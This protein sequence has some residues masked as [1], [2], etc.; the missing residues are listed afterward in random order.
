MGFLRTWNTSAKNLSGISFN[1]KEVRAK[2]VKG[3]IVGAAV[4]VVGSGSQAGRRSPL[5]V[6][7]RP[8]MSR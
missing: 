7:C 2:D 1:T 4:A 8:Q 5:G 3:A 6:A